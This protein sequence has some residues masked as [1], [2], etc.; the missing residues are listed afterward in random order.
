MKC[1][2]I[3]GVSHNN[4]GDNLLG[5]A[6][7][8][9]LSHII[10][11]DSHNIHWET[12]SIR[13][14]FD[15]NTIDYINSFDCLLI[16]GGGLFLPDTN[17]NNKSCWQWAI[18]IDLLK[19]ITIP[20]YVCAI[21]YNLFYKQSI[22]MP[23]RNNSYIWKDRFNIF[24]N[25]VECLINKS[26]LF[27]VRHHGDIHQ[28]KKIIDKSLHSKLL[29]E[30]CP[31]IKYV[32]KLRNSLSIKGSNKNIWAY[33]IKDDRSWRRYYN[34]D[35]EG[36]Y[37]ELLLFMNYV[38]DN[39]PHIEQKIL[40]HESN[41]VSFYNFLSNKNLDIEII[42]NSNQSPSKIIQNFTNINK[43]YCMAGHSQMI[44]TALKC[45]VISLITHDKLK[46]YLEDI[47]NY[48][49]ETYIDVNKDRIYEKL[50]GITK[51]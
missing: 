42:D 25:N 46:Y 15:I 35:R 45:D 37:Y 11:S 1:L 50:V 41:N 10:F 30:Y 36:F 23:N 20:I 31:T 13:D 5:Y 51:F 39:A 28:L 34:I 8:W 18:E 43:L 40:L 14:N 22:C 48:R 47:N 33:E 9:W 17:P 6:S 38:K 12:K 24:K 32:Q 44:G 4:A 49:D 7:K 27:T 3:Y 2:H 19:K 16:G 29:F 26:T 21:G